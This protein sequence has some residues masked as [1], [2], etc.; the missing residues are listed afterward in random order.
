[1]D[2]KQNLYYALGIFSYAVAKA[3]GTVQL[4]EKEEL[5]KIVAEEID[6]DI[7]F[8]YVDII[9]Q[10]LQ[11]DKPGFKDVHQWAL[12]ALERG[13]YHLTEDI[14]NQF[15]NVLK[16]VAAAFPPKSE[17]EHELINIFIQEIRDF[18]VNMTID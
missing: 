8:Q 1:M 9:F 18:R 15:I 17:E 10:I 7:D 14:K 11:K 16:R 4:E 12:D 5:Q 13:K 2:S 6:H 3:D